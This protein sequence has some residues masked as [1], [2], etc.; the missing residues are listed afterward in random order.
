MQEFMCTDTTNVE[1]EMHD[2]TSN[3]WYQPEK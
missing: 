1:H 3:N 2:H